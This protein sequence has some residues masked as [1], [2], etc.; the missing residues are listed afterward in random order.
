[1][2]RFVYPAFSNHWS[3]ALKAATTSGALPRSAWKT[4]RSMYTS[5]PLRLFG[6]CSDGRA[7]TPVVDEPGAEAA[8]ALVVGPV[9]AHADEPG[10]VTTCD[11]GGVG[12]VPTGVHAQLDLSSAVFHS[13]CLARVEKRREASVGAGPWPGQA[14]LDVAGPAPRLRTRTQMADSHGRKPRRVIDEQDLSETL[15]LHGADLALE[16]EALVGSRGQ[17]PTGDRKSTRLNSSHA[18]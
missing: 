6:C 12:L 8:V 9:H 11:N 2:R 7:S 17:L 10:P 13:Q 14:E 4:S 3:R 1:M 15:A 16:V 18:N 5:P